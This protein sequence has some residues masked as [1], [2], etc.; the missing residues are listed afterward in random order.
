MNTAESTRK[1]AKARRRTLSV[2]CL[3]TGLLSACDPRE[4]KP[5]LDLGAFTPSSLE[6]IIAQSHSLKAPGMEVEFISRQFLGVRY[7]ENRLIGG[8]DTPETL[9]V[10]LAALDCYTYLDAVEALRRSSGY[11]DFRGQVAAVRYA[12]GQV[13]WRTRHHFFSDWVA[14][15]GPIRDVTAEVGGDA[16]VADVKHLNHDV[17]GAPVLKGVA[18]RVRRIVH[19]PSKRL[20]EAMIER[21]RTGDYIGIYAEAPWLD[22]THT[23]IVVKRPD[24]TGIRHA[25][26]ARDKRAVV[27]E[28]LLA[29]VRGKPGIVVYRVAL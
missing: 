21:L 17:E 3:L 24:G 2:L 10:N 4:P 7:G 1:P 23:G 11:A 13:A 16:A 28:D 14:S 8:A 12:R 15:G 25:S 5:T 9:T 20:E 18:A 26:A 27:E 29:Y 22:V 6:E 19:I